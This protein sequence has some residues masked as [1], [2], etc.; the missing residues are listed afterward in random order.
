MTVENKAHIILADDCDWTVDNISVEDDAVLSVYSQSAG[1][2]SGKLTIKGNLG[3]TDGNIGD[4]GIGGKGGQSTGLTEKKKGQNGEAGSSGGSGGNCGT[5]VING[6]IVTAANIGG[7]NGGEGGIGG[8]GGYG[9]RG[10]KKSK[11]GGGG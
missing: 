1:E 2:N 4:A 7:G 9:G 8:K 3:G 11:S 10:G 5:I 6:G